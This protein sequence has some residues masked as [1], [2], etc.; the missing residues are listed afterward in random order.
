MAEQPNDDVSFKPTE[1]PPMA[2]QPILPAWLEPR[3]QNVSNPYAVSGQME[4]LSS[5]Q[6][7]SSVG[8][9]VGLMAV[10]TFGLMTVA[11]GLGILMAILFVPP[12]VRTIV[13]AQHRVAQRRPTSSSEQVLLFAGSFGVTLVVSLVVLVSAFGTFC[14]VCLS[15]GGDEQTI[16]VALLSAGVATLASC[17]PLFYWIRYRWRRHTQGP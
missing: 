2:E 12:M 1:L 3:S 16:P 8:I 6:R 10:V 7:V 5:G 17:V 13:V 9:L 14:F 4:S 15:G 11:P